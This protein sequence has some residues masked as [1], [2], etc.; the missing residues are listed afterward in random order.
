MKRQTKYIYLA[1]IQQHFGAYGWED[2]SEYATDS[3]YF[4]IEKSDKP[5]PI[6]GRPESLLNHD[7]REYKMHGFPTRVIHRRELN[8][9]NV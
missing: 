4:P 3:T 2:V 6:T 1:V 7:L 5:N 9:A 8:T